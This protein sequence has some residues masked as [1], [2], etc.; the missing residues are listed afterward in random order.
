M[1]LSYLS[2]IEIVNNTNIQWSFFFLGLTM[3]SV[4]A[5]D[6]ILKLFNKF[7][8]PIKIDCKSKYRD[9]LK[10]G[11][12]LWF[13]IRNSSSKIGIE[14]VKAQLIFDDLEYDLHPNKQ[15]LEFYPGARE[16]VGLLTFTY[17]Y[18]CYS[19][20]KYTNKVI[21][22]LGTGPSITQYRVEFGREY[23]FTIKVFI[24]DKPPVIRK[25]V[26]IIQPGSSTQ[27][28]YEI[29]KKRQKQK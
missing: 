16:K 6:P 9:F 5:I 7:I 8:S 17:H 28:V 3:T 27:I 24:K 19:N 11:D 2:N 26:L 1:W 10:N 15:E 14:N 18:S 21:A 12:L 23:K 20:P 25:Y 22:V 4:V 29:I 13:Y